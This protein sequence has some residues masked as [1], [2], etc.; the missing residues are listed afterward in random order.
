MDFAFAP[1]QE[2]DDLRLV[3][4]RRKNTT[5]ISPAGVT[6]IADFFANLKTNN[7]KGGDLIIGSHGNDEGQLLIA[8]DSHSSA[9]TTFDSLQ[10]NNAITI[11]ASV[12][13]A[14][15]SVHL[16]G[17]LIGSPEC[18]PFLRLLKQKLGNLKTLSA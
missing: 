8:L 18:L 2:F 13:S 9:Q 14:D 7:L 12:K 3:L 15:T 5:V 4:S 16:F 1:G 17:C 6:N 11:P 10:A